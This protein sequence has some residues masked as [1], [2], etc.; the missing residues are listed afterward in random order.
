MKS[1]S[2]EFSL[3]E[4]VRCPAHTGQLE[5]VKTNSGGCIEMHSPQSREDEYILSA[6]FHKTQVSKHLLLYNDG[7]I[8][9]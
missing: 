3:N 9:R 7:K 5:F 4:I 1:L 8:Y 2:D 6:M